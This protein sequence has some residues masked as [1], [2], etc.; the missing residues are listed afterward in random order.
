MR[1]EIFIGIDLGTTVLK[2]AAFDGRTGRMLASA[3]KALKIRV[4]DDGAR[5][6]DPAQID[7]GLSGA[8]AA[9]RKSLPS[10]WKCVAGIGLAAQG[11]SAVIANKAS[12]EPLTPMYLWNDVRPHRYL[13]EIAAMKGRSYWR[14]LAMRDE[15]GAGLGRMRWL[16]ETQ[17]E[18]ICEANIYAGAGEYVYFRLTG[19]WRQDAG[20]AVQIGCYDVPKRKLVRGPLDLVNIGLSFVAPMRED[21]QTHPLA[22][23]AARRWHL[24]EGI[25]V[26]G[27]YMD[28]EAGYLSAM[29][30]SQHPLQCSL[31]TAWVG[32]LILAKD[33]RWSSPFQ[34]VIPAPTGA[35]WQVIQPLLT[36]NVSWDWG[37][38]TLLDRNCK[39][40]LAGLDAVFRESLLPP[41]GL[42]CLPWFAR[43]SAVIP[44]AFGAGAY[45]GLNP[46]TN[47]LDMLRALAAGMCYEFFRIFEQ[48]HALRI[49]DAVVL[50]GGASK[51]WFF[52]Q[53]FAAL[54]EPIP[55]LAL[56]EE[57][58]AGTRGA[59]YAFSRKAARASARRIRP[60]APR[61]RN[62][63]IAGFHDYV[64][65][66]EKLYARVRA[67]GTLR[68]Q[69]GP[70]A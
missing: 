13:R 29:G 59:I 38:E 34:L 31:G 68:F 37:L 40:A 15:P 45:I 70:A 35:G 53:F 26:A 24:P 23:S 55:V 47:R 30:L 4:G 28:H 33:A 52:Q 67:G 3:S 60:P 41:A 56:Q 18:L 48:A 2:A 51:G 11:G 64:R 69:K 21:H 63:I 36:G 12:G 43:P 58:L 20:N 19:T 7:R 5:E 32:N 62:R 16:Q 66:Y 46:R 17:P 22:R 50:G 27:P 65:A 8:L 44:E 10:Q 57:D 42:I 25:P 9:I 39:K 61:V 1:R 6:L 49:M 54:F 14:R